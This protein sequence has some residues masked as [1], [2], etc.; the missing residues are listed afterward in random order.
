MSINVQICSTFV[1]LEKEVL[2]TTIMSI[3]HIPSM[4]YWDAVV[5]KALGTINR[6]SS[7]IIKV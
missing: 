4:S 5:R 2:K 6:K 1:K 7:G 3:N